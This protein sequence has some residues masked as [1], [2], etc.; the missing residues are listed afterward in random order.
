[1]MMILFRENEDVKWDWTPLKHK[2]EPGVGALGS[3]N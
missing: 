1:M 2:H 3:S